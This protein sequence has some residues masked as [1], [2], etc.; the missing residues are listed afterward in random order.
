MI[1]RATFGA[2]GYLWYLMAFHGAVTPSV[3]CWLVQ[4]VSGHIRILLSH[5]WLQ[6]QHWL[7]GANDT[8]WLSDVWIV[9]YKRVCGL[10]NPL[11]HWDKRRSSLVAADVVSQSV[12]QSG[13]ITAAAVASVISPVG[14]ATPFSRKNWKTWKQNE[15]GVR[16]GISFKI[17]SSVI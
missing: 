16:H 6:L 15:L 14:K 8:P 4:R 2:T 10:C 1:M 13:G 11:S 12:S 7:T 3:L 5:V 9:L 17:D